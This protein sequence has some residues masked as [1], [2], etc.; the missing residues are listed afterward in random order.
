MTEK[1]EPNLIEA[2]ISAYAKLNNISVEEATKKFL[3]TQDQ[4]EKSGIPGAQQSAEEHRQLIKK[5]RR[6]K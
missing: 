2:A 5:G 3:N 1:K 4:L 6:K